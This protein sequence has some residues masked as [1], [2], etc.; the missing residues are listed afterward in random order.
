MK[1]AMLPADTFIVINKTILNDQDR[2]IL[3]MLYQPIIGTIAVNLYFT[4]WSY[5]DKSEIL[6]EIWSHHHLITNMGI[7]LSEIMEARQKLEAIGLLKTYYKEGNVNSYAYLLYSPMSAYDFLNNPIL[8]TALYSN[9]GSKEY[10]STV[11]YFKTPRIKLSEFTDISCSFRD[12]FEMSSVYNVNNEDIRKVSQNGIDILSKVD[13]DNVLSV[14][15]NDLLNYKTVTRE[16]R[17]LIQ[18][19]S[20]TYDLND[21]E[22]TE[23]IRSSINEKH[24]IDKEELKHNC[25]EYYQFNNSGK[26]PSLIFRTQPE[27]LRKP[28]GDNSPKAKIIYQFETTTPYDFI[29]S[30]YKDSRPTESDLKIIE[31][32]LVELKMNPGVIN[33]LIDYV[34]KIN[35]NKLTKGFVE[36]I[37]AQWKKSKIE[38]V[39]EAMNIAIKELKSKKNIDKNKSSTPNRRVVSKPTWFDKDIESNED[40]NDEQELEKLLAEFR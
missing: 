20:L 36:V 3:V 4:L 30:K 7:K 23:I 15:P 29:A 17:E 16:V 19:L 26:L 21:D 1:V 31:Y 18:K 35:N 12:I 2:K 37:A 5:L 33:V 27:Y 9:V 38:T 13:V 22:M 25:R 14:I 10:K 34:L 11:E 6:S 24:S 8:S 32:L 28:V 39:E 40:S